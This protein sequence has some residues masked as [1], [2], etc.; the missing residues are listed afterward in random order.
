MSN[1]MQVFFMYA[2]VCVCVFL[3]DNEKQKHGESDGKRGGER[4]RKN[5]RIIFAASIHIISTHC[6]TTMLK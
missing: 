3:F 6:P 5:K 2:F 1:L 4:E